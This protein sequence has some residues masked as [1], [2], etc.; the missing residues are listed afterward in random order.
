MMYSFVRIGLLGLFGWLVVLPISIQASDSITLEWVIEEALHNNPRIVA[1][2]TRWEARK[3]EEPQARSLDDPRL[4][5]MFWAVPDD[6]PNPFAARET[7]F[8]IKQRFPFPGKLKL[9]GQIAQQTAAMAGHGY[10]IVQEEIRQKVKL[11]Y[12]DLFLIDR[13]LEIT[14]KHLELMREFVQIASVRYATGAVAQGDVLKAQVEVSDLGNRVLVLAQRRRAGVAKL[15]TLMDRE[16]ETVLGSLADF[17]IRP[18]GYTLD[19]LKQMAMKN[20]PEL[21]AVTVAIEKSETA[22]ALAKKAYYPDLM[23]DFSYWNVRNN[24]NRWMLM[25]EAKVPVAF[26]SKG[27]HDARVRQAE[28]EKRAWQADYEDVKNQILYA[29]EEA[30]V[31]IQV[32]WNNV[33]LYQDVIIP[34]AQQTVAA[35][36]ANYETDRATFLSLVDS[37]RTLLRFELDYYKA[38]VAFEKGQADLVRAIGTTLL[39]SGYD[40]GVKNDTK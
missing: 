37:E 8:G 1:A 20:R 4:Y 35:I 17:P 6:T 24:T 22:K 11:A 5:T 26:W 28:V 7:W 15:N 3:E 25:I 18:M 34:Q 39:E 36:Q 27:K 23:A 38:L 2:L 31:N 16:P 10:L 12:Y 14:R 40:E 19:T 29:V 33:D 13:E 32:A 9:R 21:M 30:F